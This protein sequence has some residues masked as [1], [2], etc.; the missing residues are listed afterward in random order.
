MP[1]DAANITKIQKITWM[2]W[3][4]ETQRL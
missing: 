2:Q 3:P 4:D 1:K